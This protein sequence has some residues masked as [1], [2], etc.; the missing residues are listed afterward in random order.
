MSDIGTFAVD[1]GELRKEAR[2][3]SVRQRRLVEAEDLAD[4]GLAKGYKF[5]LLA[6]NAGLGDEH[7]RFISS[8]VTALGQGISTFDYL[9]AALR[10]TANAYDGVDAT[11]SES[12]TDLRRRLPR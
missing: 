10:S 6:Q 1:S 7:D 4:N 12:H 2:E 5:G 11:V 3:W 9:R 8:M